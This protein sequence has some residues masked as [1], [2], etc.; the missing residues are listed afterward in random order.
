MTIQG[1]VT[2]T[3]SLEMTSGT[4]ANVGMLV[5]SGDNSRFDGDITLT[6]GNLA[7]GMATA[8]G[9]GALTLGDGTDKNGD[10]ARRTDLATAQMEPSAT[11]CP[12]L[13]HLS[14]ASRPLAT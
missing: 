13:A 14:W 2:G 3:G 9:T 6:G 1:N 7:I 8:L 12:S 5:L 4:Q 11:T 10:T